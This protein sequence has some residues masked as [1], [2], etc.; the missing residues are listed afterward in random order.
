MSA[1]RHARSMIK[2]DEYLERVV[3][4][5]QRVTTHD[6]EVRWNEKLNGRQ[7]DVVVRFRIGTLRYLVLVE[8]KNRTRKASAEDVEAF[9][10]KSRDQNTS[11][12]VFVT[13]AGFQ[14]GALNVAR[15][16]G[17][18]CF[19]VRFDSS[20]VEASRILTTISMSPN[21]NHAIVGTAPNVEL[22]EDTLVANVDATIVVYENGEKQNLPTDNSQMSYYANKSLLHDGRSIEQLLIDIPLTQFQLGQK[23]TVVVPIDPSQELTPPDDAFFRAGRIKAIE[24]KITGRVGKPM[25]GEHLVD[26]GILRS[27]IIYT[28]VL[29]GEEAEFQLDEIPLG[30]GLAKEGEFYFCPQPLIYYYIDKIVDDLMTIHLIESFQNNEL[31]RATFTQKRV[32]S[33]RM[34]PVTDAKILKRLQ[35]R[36]V[37]YRLLSGC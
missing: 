13:V 19:T 11:K 23:R 17:I 6:A 7:F 25:L 24:F 33:S 10:T 14:S 36:L 9:V 21:S 30:T 28:N 29:T 12:A 16:H 35:R 37:D 32:H 27:P 5:I 1:W 31:I 18:D 20:R 2:A 3:A 15:R 22:G 26:P 4:G 8:V 34:I